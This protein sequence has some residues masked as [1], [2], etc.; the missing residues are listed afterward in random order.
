MKSF[1]PRL[2]IL[3]PEQRALWPELKHVPRDFVL[4]EGTGLA[5]RFRAQAVHRF[6]FL[7]LGTFSGRGTRVEGSLF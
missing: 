6:R 5:L 3:P 4:H 7:L 1:R 2:D